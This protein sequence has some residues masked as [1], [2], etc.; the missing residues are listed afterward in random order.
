LY[1]KR[2]ALPCGP[3]IGRKRSSRVSQNQG[4][5]NL[6]TPALQLVSNASVSA[7]VYSPFNLKAATMMGFPRRPRTSPHPPGCAML[8]KALPYGSRAAASSRHFG[9]GADFPPQ[10]LR[11]ILMP[12]LT[13]A[14]S[15]LLRLLRQWAQLLG[16]LTAWDRIVQSTPTR[17]QEGR[18]FGSN[19]GN[20]RMFTYVP[21]SLPNSAALVVV[22]HGCTCRRPSAMT[23][24]RA[25]RPSPTGTRSLCCFRS[26]NPPTT[27]DA[28]STGFSP[29]T[30]RATTAR[31]S[32]S[33]R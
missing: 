11:T 25:G 3:V 6:V 23:T 18:D 13:D 33:G 15:H 22:L 26:N 28:A 2:T 12:Y 14:L 16:D 4:Q 29:R 7:N 30:A 20:L 1:A 24:A 27:W 5:N 10:R 8:V 21:D 19:P 9:S 32:R 17:L 31:R